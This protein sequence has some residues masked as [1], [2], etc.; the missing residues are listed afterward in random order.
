MVSVTLQP[1]YPRVIDPVPIVREAGWASGPVWTVAENLAPTRIRTPDRPVHSE[2]L[3]RLSYPGHRIP[4]VPHENPVRRS[5]FI[6]KERR[7]CQTD[8]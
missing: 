2:S 7:Y 6:I 8:N 5:R 1:L 3:Y 4:E